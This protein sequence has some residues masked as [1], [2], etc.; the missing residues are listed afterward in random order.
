MRK[1]VTKDI[2]VETVEAFH[3]IRI[4]IMLNNLGE[5]ESFQ[6]SM[7]DWDDD[8]ANYL[9]EFIPKDDEC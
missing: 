5:L 8:L 1:E 4:T 3:P 9:E 2:I 7:E 6:R